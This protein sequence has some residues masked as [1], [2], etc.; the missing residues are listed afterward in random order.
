MSRRHTLRNPR[1]LPKGGRAR[2]HVRKEYIEARLP[3][4]RVLGVFG[5]D[6]ALEE[7]DGVNP[8]TATAV[9]CGRVV[10][11]LGANRRT[12]RNLSRETRFVS[13]GRARRENISKGAILHQI[14]EDEKARHALSEID[15]KRKKGRRKAA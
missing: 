8:S 3:D 12:R 6:G 9:F 2:R 1:R 7:T 14:H 5:D 11:Q 13:T 4:A 10:Y 15:A